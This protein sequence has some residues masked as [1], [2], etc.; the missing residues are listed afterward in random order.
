MRKR[1]AKKS[2]EILK[3]LPRAGLLVVIFGLLCTV[4]PIW[5]EGKDMGFDLLA[6]AVVFQSILIIIIVEKVYR[7]EGK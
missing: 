3:P 5:F 7:N 1:Y 2:Q 6:S 4:P